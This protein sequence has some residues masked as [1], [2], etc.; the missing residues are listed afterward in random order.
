VTSTLELRDAIVAAGDRLAVDD[1]GA[2]A[3]P[4]KSVNKK[5][6]RFGA[7]PNELEL[8]AQER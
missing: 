4:R 5:A 2:R 6:C 1:A 3:R 8:I 7:S